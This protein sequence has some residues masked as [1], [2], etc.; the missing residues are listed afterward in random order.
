MSSD[1]LISSEKHTGRTARLDPPVSIRVSARSYFVGFLLSTFLAALLFYFE[2]NIFAVIFFT[3]GFGLLVLS[4]L[5]RLKFDG[6][7][8]IRTGLLPQLGARVNHSLSSI[9]LIHIEQVETQAIR[10]WK[11]GGRVRYTY[12]TSMR[13]KGM[14]FSFSS[15]GGDFGEMIR[16]ILPRLGENVLDN[17]SLELRDYFSERKDAEQKAAFSQI[18]PVDVLEGLLR[19]LKWKGKNA[20]NSNMEETD[21]ENGEKAEALRRLGNELRLSGSL[22]Q[23]VEAFRR[24]L[25][26]Q[27]ANGWLLFEFARCLQSFAGSERD[28]RIERKAFA[29]MRL[30]ERRAGNDADLLSR[31]G[32]NYFQ[33]GEWRRAGIVFNMAIE[34]MGESFRSLRGLAEIALREGKIAHVIHNFASAHRLAESPALKRWTKGEVEYFSRINED[35]EYMELELSRLNLLDT[36]SR[37]KKSALRI[38]ITGFPIILAGLLIDNL[39]IVN[40]GW[41]VSGVSLLAWAAII[42]LRRILNARIPFHLVEED[43]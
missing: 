35:G 2:Y 18:P 11:R 7:R 42:L 14:T 28:K 34:R 39:T 15:G 21:L 24:A 37:A 36:L 31:L 43:E 8:L 19:D 29:L 20:V 27:P 10:T 30:A 6:R 12:R 17:R 5:D 9:K 33:I 40:L 32:E 13:G 38:A 26:L 22:L 16:A 3:A 4:Y 23:A 41:T 25:V 1:P